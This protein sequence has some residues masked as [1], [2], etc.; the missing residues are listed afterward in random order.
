MSDTNKASFFNVKSYLV[1]ITFKF[2]TDSIIILQ[3]L[4]RSL[5]PREC[6]EFTLEKNLP[7]IGNRRIHYITGNLVYNYK[8]QQI[9]AYSNKNKLIGIYNYTK[10]KDLANHISKVEILGEYD[11]DNDSIPDNLG[12]Q[13]CTDPGLYTVRNRRYTYEGE[14]FILN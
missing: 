4:V 1:E 10:F 7:F 9:Y 11:D 8:F 14:S 12:D 2:D 6:L 13:V 5:N 3:T